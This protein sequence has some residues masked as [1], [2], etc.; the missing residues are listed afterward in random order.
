MAKPRDQIYIEHIFKAISLIEK[1][2]AGKTV[3]DFQRDPM[4]SS[5]V[6]YDKI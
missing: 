1:F 6:I 5:A 3:V 2:V 4:L